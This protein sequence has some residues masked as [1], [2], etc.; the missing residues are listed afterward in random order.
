MRRC[1]KIPL[2]QKMPHGESTSRL[3]HRVQSP[4]DGTPVWSPRR[5]P[6]L[7]HGGRHAI[8]VKEEIEILDLTHPSRDK[9]A[10]NL[11]SRLVVICNEMRI[12]HTQEAKYFISRVTC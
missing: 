11:D 2:R 6:S 10:I 8:S 7:P 9:F 1:L 5:Q 3:V 4:G 12:H